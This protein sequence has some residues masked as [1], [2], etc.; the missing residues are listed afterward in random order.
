MA[1]L[2][3]YEQEWIEKFNKGL[4]NGIKYSYETKSPHSKIRNHYFVEIKNGIINVVIEEYGKSFSSEGRESFSDKTQKILTNDR[5][6]VNLFKRDK[7]RYKNHL[8]FSEFDAE[9]AAK[10]AAEQAERLKSIIINNDSIGKVIDNIPVG[11]KN[12]KNK[13]IFAIGGLAL[14]GIGAYII[15]KMTD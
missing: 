5:E 9:K 1:K 15:K 11:N 12:S 8:D 2:K 14:L 3:P 7:F 13:S 10:K 6:I 4:L